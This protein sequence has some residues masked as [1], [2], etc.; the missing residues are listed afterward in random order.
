[1]IR[2]EDAGPEDGPALDAM[3]S[4]C[5]ADTFAH[6]CSAEDRATYLATA[7]GPNG[8]LLR[9]LTDPAHRF[10]L[11]RD[12]DA[13]AGYAKLSEP[14]LAPGL[15]GPRAQQLSQLYVAKHWQGAGIAQTLMDWTM[16]T[17]RELGADELLLTV[18]E[19]ND[20]AIRFYRRYGFE[21][22][23]DYAFQVGNQTDRD[24]IMRIAL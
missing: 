12:G 1:M 2:Y 22:I 4:A 15:Y 3:A 13:I 23:G 17:A 19:G 9:H 16:E 20:R 6:T 21:H 8:T 11:A 18:W 10:R 7:Y 14:W 5:W 24:L